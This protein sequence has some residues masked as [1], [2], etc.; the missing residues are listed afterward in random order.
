MTRHNLRQLIVQALLFV[1]VLAVISIVR[2]DL[3]ALLLRLDLW[4]RAIFADTWSEIKA[5]GVIAIGAAIVGW[6]FRWWLEPLFN[7]LTNP[8][9]RWEK[10][11]QA[12]EE[13]YLE[14]LTR[15]ITEDL[16]DRVSM[17]VWPFALKTRVGFESRFRSYHTYA[18]EIKPQLST[19]YMT[20]LGEFDEAAYEALGGK[21]VPLLPL[22]ARYPRVAVL[23]EP[24]SG[25]SITLKNA[26]LTF[27]DQNKRTTRPQL[28]LYIDLKHFTSQ[29]PADS[30]KDV[31]RFIQSYIEQYYGDAKFLKDRLEKYLKE[32][33]LIIL[34]DSMNE[35]PPNDYLD[36]VNALKDFARSIGM[37]N[38]V[39]F[40]CR[41]LHYEEFGDRLGE[42]HWLVIERL[43]TLQEIESFAE[44]Y[45]EAE[46]V[47]NLVHHLKKESPKLFQAC[48]NP[49]VLYMTCMVATTQILSDDSLLPKN[50]S[51]LFA[52]FTHYAVLQVL[53]ALSQPP[54]PEEAE[55][56]FAKVV[57]Y[58]S[59]IAFGMNENKILGTEIKIDQIGSY[60]GVS[61]DKQLLQLASSAR[62]ITVT[63]TGGLVFMHHVLQEYFAASVLQ[64]YL[65]SGKD[66][67]RYLDNPWWEETAVL[68][69]GLTD[70]IDSLV[71]HMLAAGSTSSSRLFLIAK[72]IGN[73][74]AEP[75]ESLLSELLSCLR[76]ELASSPVRR[77]KAIQ[78]LGYLDVPQVAEM[79]KTTLENPDLDFVYENALR[80]IFNLSS[81]DAKKAGK[82]FLRR[83]MPFWKI[84][85]NSELRRFLRPFDFITA[86]ILRYAR[87]FLLLLA[88]LGAI[89]FLGVPALTS[90]PPHISVPPPKPV[91]T[92]STSVILPTERPAPP[93]PNADPYQET[94]DLFHLGI[95]VV[96]LAVTSTLF[97][98]GVL[99]GG[100]RFRLLGVLC[101]VG[102]FGLIV[103]SSV[104]G[105]GKYFTNLQISAAAV[106]LFILFSV[107]QFSSSVIRR[108]LAGSKTENLTWG[109]P[110]LVILLLFAID[111]CV[112]AWVVIAQRHWLENLWFFVTTAEVFRL[113]ERLF[114]LSLGYVVLWLVM[115][116]TVTGLGT[117]GGQLDNL[118][119]LLLF[120]A[121]RS[122]S[123]QQVLPLAERMFLVMNNG[124]A[125][126]VLRT[127]AIDNLRRLMAPREI[128]PSLYRLIN[129]PATPAPVV[130]A[131]WDA[132]YAINARLTRELKARGSC[133][134]GSEVTSLLAILSQENEF[135][136]DLTHA[137]DDAARAYPHEFRLQMDAVRQ[138]VTHQEYARVRNILDSLK[139][140]P[141][142]ASQRTLLA[143]ISEAMMRHE[144]GV[145]PADDLVKAVDYSMFVYKDAAAAEQERAETA[146]IL[147]RLWRS[148][149]IR[150]YRIFVMKERLTREYER[151]VNELRPLQ[152]DKRTER[153][154]SEALL[155]LGLL[156]Y[157]SGNWEY[158]A[159][160]LQEGIERRLKYWGK[161][162]FGI[163][164][165]LGNIGKHDLAISLLTEVIETSP[166]EIVPYLHRSYYLAEAGRLD[167]AKADLAQ[168]EKLIK[169]GL[170][171]KPLKVSY[172]SPFVYE[173]GWIHYHTGEFQEA[174]ECFSEAIR[175]FPRNIAYRCDLGLCLLHLGQIEQAKREYAQVVKLRK[176][177]GTAALFLRVVI[178]DL[179]SAM[180]KK[181]D[182]KGGTEILAMLQ[183]E[184]LRYKKN[185][186]KKWP[187]LVEH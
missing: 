116:V 65:A 79:L 133:S 13:R 165:R 2:D 80:S 84:I 36:R 70:D 187:S 120:V 61:A 152:P 3:I 17:R 64:D 49:Y 115:V 129:Y 34:F 153:Q 99:F 112:V 158:A 148:V 108:W 59:Q 169:P 77:V 101:T 144:K 89:A 104:Q 154:F 85:L 173:A 111:V 26:V 62:L 52:Q 19:E 167:E 22:L 95:N 40:A 66:I 140:E 39:I 141:L 183:K 134:E 47:K 81:Q 142:D 68:F 28:P 181:P 58:L 149:R 186:E 102:F 63:P 184:Y 132:V 50:K 171:S 87:T 43:R 29:Y 172:A 15:L 105:Q 131:A 150:T 27:A 162:Y 98:R 12:Q 78:A 56:Q 118:R 135:Y 54:R 83:K 97:F 76:E 91:P 8:R 121:A 30:H 18:R 147:A 178:R 31:I 9:W 114:F 32:E 25:K 185:S 157:S 113:P 175:R 67:Y 55:A 51:E 37:K 107:I 174:S 156:Y 24:G 45:L 100:S 88:V 109:I 164:L 82:E 160:V 71:R 125:W 122:R 124:R 106:L 74:T 57:G 21:R 170:V 137:Y 177:R 179:E 4:G 96:T 146:S 127:F 23:G 159:L 103:F 16:F 117:L 86:A 33:R 139:G 1:V 182:L 11:L 123:I 155:E 41:S 72:C 126:P 151:M 46:Q 75:Q 53:D 5:T 42:I 38:K 69:A 93:I 161:W 168:A 119:Q 60:M 176:H 166:R 130:S 94:T 14:D 7:R 145:T 10:G 136:P 110:G 138:F 20:D 35:M 73:A 128:V 48:Q 90:P 180:D 6:L 143:Q 163:A 92:P 44:V